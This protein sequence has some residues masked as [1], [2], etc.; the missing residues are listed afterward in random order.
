MRNGKNSR[1]VDLLSRRILLNVPL[2]VG[3]LCAFAKTDV[4]LWRPVAGNVLERTS[5][6]GV[7]GC[8]S[9]L[10]TDLCHGWAGKT[11]WRACDVAV[12][13][14]CGGEQSDAEDC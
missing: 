1:E 4:A 5:A 13:K 8:D 14:D 10:A 12:S 7:D 2:V 11:S 9:G 3:E 6:V